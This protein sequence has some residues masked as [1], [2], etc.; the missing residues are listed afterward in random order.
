MAQPPQNHNHQPG[1]RLPLL[2]V[3]GV[4]LMVGV[5][6]LA[7]AVV[8]RAADAGRRVVALLPRVPSVSPQPHPPGEV[9]LA[10]A[11]EAR[12]LFNA[13][14][15]PPATSPRCTPAW[16]SGFDLSNPVHTAACNTAAAFFIFAL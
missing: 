2:D 14:E 4:R 16:S 10:V 5:A 9:V 7:G 6:L 3:A 8:H 11:V 1:H 12:C 15:S 13:E